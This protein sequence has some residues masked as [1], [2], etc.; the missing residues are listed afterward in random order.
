M[1]DLG[2][3]VTIRNKIRHRAGPRTRAKKEKNLEK[4]EQLVFSGL[5]SSA[6]LARSQWAHVDRLRWLPE[7]GRY[8]VSGLSLMGD[9]PDFEPVKFETDRPL[10]DNS[11]Y[12]FTLH[13]EIIPLSPFCILSDCPACLA[14]EL[15][16]PDRL[17][18]STALLKSLDRG[19][20]L[21][22]DMVFERLAP[23]N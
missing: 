4:L 14:P 12:V 7:I 20:E 2:D 6:F 19:H 5:S 16:Y 22:N 8:Q 10:A 17:T 13:G 23:S 18:G 3:L 1:A 9:H 11:L 15:Y 21:E